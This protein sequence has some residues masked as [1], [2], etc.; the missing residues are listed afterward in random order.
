[1]K[2]HPDKWVEESISDAALELRK[3]G[4]RIRRARITQRRWSPSW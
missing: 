4:T 1:M 2:K 3:G